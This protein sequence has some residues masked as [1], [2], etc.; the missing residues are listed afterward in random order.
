MILKTERL[1]LRPWEETDAREL[2]EY[3]KDPAVG[4]AAGWPPHKSVEES[5]FVIR[6]VLNAPQCYA[7]CLKED[8]KAVGAA[9]LKLHGRSDLT[10]NTNECE[11]GYWLAKPFWG[12][13]IMTEAA[14]ELIR[15]GFEDL[16]MNRIWGGYYDGNVRSA[17]VQEK[18]GFEHQWTSESVDVPLMHEKRRG[19]VNLLPKERWLAIRK[20]NIGTLP[21]TNVLDDLAEELLEGPCRVIDSF[22][23]RIS[24]QRSDA[25]FAAERFYLTP[26]R[27][28]PLRE[29]FADLMIRLNCYYDA[30]VFSEGG[31][32][33]MPDP[34]RI[35]GKVSG[36]SETDFIN[37]LYPEEKALVTLNGDDL[38]LSVYGGGEAFSDMLNKLAVSSGLFLRPGA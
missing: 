21:G 7:V 1:I 13:G 36:L 10:G 27:L 24:E 32:T 16:G 5:L 15:H 20:G 34:G 11:L 2:Y 35:F 30:A 19:H 25:Y 28:R 29:R 3:A 4:P 31:W 14:E 12:Q 6:N 38:Y 17:R 23:E 9:E 26:E 22:P 8:G 18:C 33:K 37:V